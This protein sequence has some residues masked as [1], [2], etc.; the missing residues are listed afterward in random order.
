MNKYLEII[1]TN[2]MN[3]EGYT[4]LCGNG[5][6]QKRTSFNGAQFICACGWSTLLDKEFV[7][8]YIQKWKKWNV[9]EH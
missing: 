2:L 3:L 1:K 9:K 5:N 8:K 6:C 4:P 7:S